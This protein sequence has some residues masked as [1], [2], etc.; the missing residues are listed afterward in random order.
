MA[1][2]GKDFY[3]IIAKKSGAAQKDVKRII[4]AFFETVKESVAPGEGVVI[5]G[6]GKFY[7]RKR[8]ERSVKL[9][10][11]SKVQVSPQSL[12]AFKAGSRLKNL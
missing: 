1:L 2:R 4:T 9:P 6:Y 10:N 11:G 7:L 3:G 5:T 12:V 8:K